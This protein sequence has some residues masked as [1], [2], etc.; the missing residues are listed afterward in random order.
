MKPLWKRGMLNLLDVT[1]M[2]DFF[3]ISFVC[4]ALPV[5]IVWIVS[6]TRQHETDRR[7]EVM[8][9]AIEAGEPVDVKKLGA[10]R[11]VGRSVKQELLDK[12]NGACVTSLIGV[13]LLIYA[14]IGYYNPEWVEGRLLS[15]N[16]H[17]FGGIL[18]AI[19]A[20]LFIT[21]FISRKALAKEIEAEEK[22][23]ERAAS[24]RAS[25]RPEEK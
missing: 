18:L 17:I 25:E 8:L 16:A 3:I 20:G 10:P 5:A 4:V 6:R 24:E 21:Y 9:K 23:L 19:G 13:V 2:E 12:L 14:I 22:E 1:V 15:T 7:A 11:K